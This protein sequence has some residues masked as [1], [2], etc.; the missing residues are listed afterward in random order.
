[1]RAV[2]TRARR[3]SG[4]VRVPGDKSISHR[5]VLFGAVARGTTTVSGLAPGADVRSSAACVGRL[6]VAVTASGPD[7]IQIVSPG[8]SAWKGNPVDLD[9]GNSGTSARLLM[10]MLAPATGLTA[11]IEGDPSLSGRPMRR[12]AE[13]LAEMGARITLSPS[14]TLPVTVEGHALQGTKHRLRISSAQVKTSLLLAGLAADGDTWV[15]EPEVSRDHTERLLPAF[16]VH[17]LRGADGVGVRRQELSGTAITVPGDPSSAAFLAAAAAIIP[18][19][20]VRVR[21]VGTNP[22]RTGIHDVLAEMGNPVR[23]EDA[24]AAAEPYGTWV[25]QHHALRAVTIAGAV[26]P[27]LVDEIPVLAVVAAMAEGT[28]TIRDAAELRVKESDRLK[29]VANGLKSMGAAVDELPDGLVIHGGR[30][31]RGAH[32]DSGMDHRIAMSF[33]VAGLVAD[34]ETVIEGIEW[35]DISFPGFFRLLGELTDGAVRT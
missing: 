12:V 33:A 9:A 8:R 25:C 11:R 32:I 35:A 31:L 15:R 16:G 24:V 23:V 17:L 28:T 20:N 30:P 27:R 5:A 14:G 3:F 26:V 10:G 21:G 22:T 34:G 19:S 6:G 29:L 7:A 4:D 1:M 18:G 2:V 13:P